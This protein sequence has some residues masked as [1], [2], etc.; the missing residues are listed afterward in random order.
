[1]F[2]F[3]PACLRISVS[4]PLAPSPPRSLSL[5]PTAPFLPIHQPPA[6]QGGYQP[7]PVPAA[8]SY[9]PQP[10]PPAPTGGYQPPPPPPP[11]TSSSYGYQPPAP[12]APSLA[13]GYQPPPPAA[14]PSYTPTA[15]TPSPAPTVALRKVTPVAKPPPPP[16]QPTPEPYTG[17]RSTFSS[18]PPG[19]LSRSAQPLSKVAALQDMIAAFAHV[20][21][22]SGVSIY[23]TESCVRDHLSPRVLLGG[24]LPSRLGCVAACCR[25][26]QDHA[27]FPMLCICVWVSCTCS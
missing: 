4:C 11:S 15:H 20:W 14:I 18:S 17:L 19:K 24:R 13:S 2:V 1:M 5:S 26:Q 3:L 21:T 25:G 27:P 7:P 22:V 6:A 10:A 9:Q 16:S 8:S 23:D 12:G